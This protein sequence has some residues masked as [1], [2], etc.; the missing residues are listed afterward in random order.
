MNGSTEQIEKDTLVSIVILNYR[1]RDALIR[2][3]DSALSQEYPN[4]EIILVDNGSQDGIADFLAGHAPGV[5]L[6]SLPQNLGACAGRN[7]GI[8][9]AKGNVIITLDNDIYFDSPFEVSKVVRKIAERPDIHL[10]AFRLI[11]ADTGKL[12]L[13]EWCHP[14]PW[15]SYADTEFESNF[16]VEGACAYRR[17]VFE[18]AGMYYEP[19]F[20][21]VEGHDLALRVLDHGY[22]ILYCPQIRARHLMSPLTRTPDRPYYFYTRNYIWVAQKDF[23]FLAGMRFLV[24][25]LLMMFYFMLRS[26]R[27]RAFLRGVCDGIKGWRRV[28]RDRTPIRA[29]TEK[30][31]V[32]LDRG[33][34]NL[35]VRLGRHRL[36]PQI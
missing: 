23:H 8:R 3:L 4:L 19:L 10:L 15:M 14:R 34:P 9:E 12:R 28:R 22:K 6:V 25:K 30:Y 5:K 26:K 11:D 24:P 31:L 32:D 18:T 17:E 16:F 7:A 20:I 21:G 36:E 2:S 29:S 13:R 1:R 35:L 27:Y 33:R